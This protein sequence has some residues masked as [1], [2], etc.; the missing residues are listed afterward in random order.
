MRWNEYP[1]PRRLRRA[2]LAALPSAR[3]RDGAM[4]GDRAKEGT[5]SPQNCFERAGGHAEGM[6][7]DGGAQP[8]RLKADRGV[9]VGT[10]RRA[11]V[12]S[13]LSRP[14]PNFTCTSRPYTRKGDS[15]G[16]RIVAWQGAVARGARVSYVR[17]A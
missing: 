15:Q 5:P 2:K 7:R 13:V 16:P 10:R 1:Y 6:R 17:V 11:R 12:N 3:K 4:R 9:R 14:K 8:E